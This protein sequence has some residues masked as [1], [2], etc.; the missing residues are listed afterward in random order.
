MIRTIFSLLRGDLGQEE[1]IQTLVVLAARVF[2]LLLCLPV[3]EVAHGWVAKRLGDNTATEQG[4]LRLNP[5]KHLDLFG[6]LLILTVGFGYAKPVPVNPANF[7]RPGK[8]KGFAKVAIAGPLSNLAMAALF[9]LLTWLAAVVI[10]LSQSQSLSHLVLFFS[11]VC[12]MNI[13]LAVFN[14]IPI[15]PLDGSRIVR[16]L[17]PL[18]AAV[19]MDRFEPYFGIGFF[20]V[21]LLGSFLKFDLLGAPIQFFSGIIYDAIY[22]VTGLPFRLL[23]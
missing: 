13:S 22:F 6:T 23:G 10:Y 12:Y 21:L 5:L 2:V 8:R 14:L 3:H 16:F 18:K 20:V 15:P 19:W 11:S 1:T 7:T 9:S 4:R 17:L